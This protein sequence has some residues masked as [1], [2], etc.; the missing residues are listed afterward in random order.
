MRLTAWLTTVL[1][2]KYGATAR[3]ACRPTLRQ[4][5]ATPPAKIVE[6][7]EEVRGQHLRER[8]DRC[9]TL[10]LDGLRLA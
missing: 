9:L 6:C 2:H 7:D 8:V 4:K 5:G 3:S 10:M 1:A